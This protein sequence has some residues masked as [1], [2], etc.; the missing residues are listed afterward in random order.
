MRCWPT[1]AGASV[2]HTTLLSNTPTTAVIAGSDA[3][4]VIDGPF[5][6]PGGF[7]LEAD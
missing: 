2:L 3:T 7:T 1:A 6:Q 4:L 5:Y